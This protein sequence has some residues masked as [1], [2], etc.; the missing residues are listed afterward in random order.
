MKILYVTTIGSTMVFFRELVKDLIDQGHTVDIACND[1]LAPVPDCY[2]DWPCRI[3]HHD[4]ARTPFSLGNLKALKQIR[5]LVQEE[6]YDIVHCHTPVASFCT[7]LACIGLRKKGI[8]VVYTAHGFHFYTGAPLKNW[9]LYYTAEKLCAG[10]TDLLITINHEDYHR[11]KEKL[12]VG[13]VKYVPGVGVN[14]QRF[15]KTAVDRAAKRQE[16]GVPEDAFLLIAV[17]ELNDNKNHQLLLRAMAELNYPDMH[18]IIAGEGALLQQ[19]EALA[20]DLGIGDSV[21]LLGQRDDVAQLYKIAD[22]FCFPSIREGLPVSTMEAMAAGLPLVAARNRGTVELVEEGVNG[23]LCPHDD[24]HQ[25]ADRIARLYQDTELR[26][27]MAIQS[28]QKAKAY[29]VQ[30]IVAQMEEIYASL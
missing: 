2:R 27:Q 17:G 26:N 13:A 9:L 23:F 3:F 12:K 5:K 29:D 25:F 19:H 20:R 6:K 16:L 11:A 8:K 10:M 7:R 1:A 18:C 15:A 21:H 14:T 30:M 4:C 24:V 28:G 22:L